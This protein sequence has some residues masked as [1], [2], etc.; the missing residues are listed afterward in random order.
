MDEWRGKRVTIFGLGS[1]GGGVGAARWL[2]RA[3]ARVT[4]TD[5]ADEQAL[6]ASVRALDGVPI[7]RWRLG[8]HHRDDLLAADAVVVN[9]AVKPDS[10][11]VASARTAGAVVTSEI[12]LFLAACPARV[13]GVTGTT[14]KSST[15]TMLA[16]VLEADGRR[17]W[18]GGN[19]G[20]SLLD[21]LSGM[22]ADDLLVLELSSFQLHWLS[23]QARLP[24]LAVLTNFSANHLDWH[25]TLDAYAAAK[26][27][28]FI[29]ADAVVNLGKTE[30]NR[31]FSG[32][33][34]RVIAPL[35]DGRMPE[36]AV[37]GDHQ[38]AN[39]AL[40]GAVAAALGCR[41][42]AIRRG[43]ESFRGL[44][45][46]LQ[47]VGE[48]E[49][50][51]LYNDSKATSPA[52]TLAALEACGLRTWLLAGGAPR[53]DDLAPFV[54]QLAAR[55]AGAA[56]FGAIAREL[57]A[58]ASRGA[59]NFSCAA[60]DDLPAALD[61]CWQHSRAGDA[62][63]LSPACASFDAYRDY[64]ARG[65]HFIALV[66]E[67]LASAARGAKLLSDSGA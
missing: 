31:W 53:S 11:W 36:L 52:A 30:D 32:A 18:L 21:D 25:G 50:R 35:D 9:P 1:H 28:L 20:G 13:I 3:G 38:R 23:D 15:A 4:V 58:L 5:Q 60:F 7:E 66:D 46:R 6:A 51:R 33:A 42:D 67:L 10:P 22:T 17:A 24:S 8:S 40:A 27:R 59:P 49:G 41:P 12:E 37:P 48:I 54:T 55:A 63:V 34:S 16:R 45:H 39:A 29:H 26:R 65:E 44:P 57:L 62:I 56:F 61:W 2:A 47:C 14:G 64:A 43:L 19:L